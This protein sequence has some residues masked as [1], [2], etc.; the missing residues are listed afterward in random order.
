MVFQIDSERRHNKRKVP[1]FANKSNAGLDGLERPRESSV[2]KFLIEAAQILQLIAVEETASPLL[3]EDHCISEPDTEEL[4]PSLNN[5]SVT[6]RRDALNLLGERNFLRAEQKPEKVNGF[7]PLRDHVNGEH[8]ER[9][10][11]APVCQAGN[12]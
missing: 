4:H 6:K 12:E 9:G 3:T 7:L 8:L 11:I 5:I 1:I 2:R 10:G